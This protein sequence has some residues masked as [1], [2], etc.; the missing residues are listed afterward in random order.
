MFVAAGA[1][2]K[3]RAKEKERFIN[4]SLVTLMEEAEK[5]EISK[6]EVIDLICKMEECEK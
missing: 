5:L 4:E 3:I 1:K 6:Q 2:E